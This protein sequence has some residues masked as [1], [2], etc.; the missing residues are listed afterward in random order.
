MARHQINSISSHIF[1]LRFATIWAQFCRHPA[2]GEALLVTNFTPTR[3]FC[4]VRLPT[5]DP[6]SSQCVSRRVLAN[7]RRC[8][9]ARA[10]SICLHTVPPHACIIRYTPVSP[11]IQHGSSGLREKTVPEIMVFL[12]IISDAEI[13]RFWKITRFLG[14]QA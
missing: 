10:R 1:L 8:S 6:A 7:W 11:S 4:R 2:D 12:F 14:R 9:G 13:D 3:P 5:G